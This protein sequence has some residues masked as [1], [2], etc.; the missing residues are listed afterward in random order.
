MPNKP[1]A[2][3]LIPAGS[4]AAA[5]SDKQALDPDADRAAVELV[6]EQ[7]SLAAPANPAA[8]ASESGGT[9]A[10]ATYYYKITAVNAAGESL[11]SAEVNGV[12]AGATGSIAL[13]WDAVTGA[14]GYRIY[15]GP[16]AAGEDHYFSSATA[17]FT[18]VGATGT[19]GTVPV[20]TPTIT[21]K[22]QLSLDGT[23]WFDAQYVTDSS[24][25][26]ATATR[27]MTA[28]GTQVNFLRLADRGWRFVRVVTTTVARV[29]YRADLFQ[30]D[31]D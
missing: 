4:L 22:A 16:S 11:G 12:I 27:S 17:S 8:V 20:A 1:D 13:T 26:V 9:L 28:A 14:T 25:T 21:W 31:T 18:D 10:A 24:D 5:T 15:R 3:A 2:V 6:V 19:A 23:T 7:I 29:A 30:G